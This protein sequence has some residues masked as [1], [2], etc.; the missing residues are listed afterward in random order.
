MEHSLRLATSVT[1]NTPWQIEEDGNYAISSTLRL[2]WIK[3]EIC[4]R[5]TMDNPMK[6][7]F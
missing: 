6:L 2:Q 1:E 7:V 4:N 3:L 5:K